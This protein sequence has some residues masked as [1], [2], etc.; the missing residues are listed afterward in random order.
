MFI[1]CASRYYITRV[2][3]AIKINFHSDVRPYK[4]LLA[5]QLLKVVWALS[6]QTKRANYICL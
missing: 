1:N 2:Y 4:L 5:H 3:Y 6:V